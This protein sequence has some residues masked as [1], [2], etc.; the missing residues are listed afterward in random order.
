MMK[1]Y[2]RVEPG[3]REAAKGDVEVKDLKKTPS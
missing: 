1:G 2:E 3:G